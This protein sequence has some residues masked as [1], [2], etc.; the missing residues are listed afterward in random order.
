[1]RGANADRQNRKVTEKILD[2]G[3]VY[4]RVVDDQPVDGPGGFSM[5]HIDAEAEVVGFRSVWRPLG[6]RLGKVKIK[7]PEEAMDGFASGPR[8]S[9]A[10]PPSSRPPL[11]IS[12]SDRSTARRRSNP[13]TLSSMLCAMAKSP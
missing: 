12:S 5:V 9:V 8:N 10:T 2:A 13:S 3:V 6:K 11:G 4:G 1:M 7:P